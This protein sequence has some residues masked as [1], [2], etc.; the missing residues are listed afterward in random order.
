MLTQPVL[1]GS[2]GLLRPGGTE[3][4]PA[5]AQGCP[6]QGCQCSQEAE[7]LFQVLRSLAAAMHVP[8]SLYRDVCVWQEVPFS[9]HGSL[10]FAQLEGCTGPTCSCIHGSS[11][12]CGDLPL[13]AAKLACPALGTILD[14]LDR[15][16][17]LGPGQL[18]KIRP[19]Q[20]PSLATDASL[21][22]GQHMFAWLHSL[23]ALVSGLLLTLHIIYPHLKSVKCQVY[24]NDNQSRHASLLL[25]GARCWADCMVS[26]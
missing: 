12:P 22:S 7:G 17:Y 21:G 25:H 23:I 8:V 15:R 9:S 24:V 18:G 1:V 11:R 2:A 19:D 6:G 13:L 26:I 4:L 3:G 10:V 16:G 14:V 20:M 5:E